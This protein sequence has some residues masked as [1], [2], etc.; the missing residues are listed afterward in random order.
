MEGLADG[1]YYSIPDFLRHQDSNP[2]TI[3]DIHVFGYSVTK[4][5]KGQRLGRKEETKK[6]KCKTDK[7]KDDVRPELIK[8]YDT[9]YKQTGKKIN[10]YDLRRKAKEIAKRFNNK[11]NFK[12]S[13]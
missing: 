7:I 4:L 8:Y 13:D 12:D 5:I 3:N 10:V 9:E 6:R 2:L 1:K 11:Y